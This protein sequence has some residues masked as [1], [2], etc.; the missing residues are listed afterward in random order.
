MVNAISSIEWLDKPADNCT[1]WLDKPSDNFTECIDK[2]VD[3]CTEW[4]LHWM[5]R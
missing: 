5:I 4:Q 1:K 2:P 3:K